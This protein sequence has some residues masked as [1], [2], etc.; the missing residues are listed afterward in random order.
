MYK[1]IDSEHQQICFLHFNQ[2]CGMQLDTQNEWVKH[3]DKLPWKAWEAPYAA[4]FTGIKGNVAKPSRMV[5]GSLIIQLRMGLTDRDLVNQI[6]ENP[7]YQYFIG[8]KEFQHNPPFVPTLL[9]EWRKRISVDFIIKANDILSAA[10]PQAPKDQR[11]FGLKVSGTLVATQICDA[12]VAPQNIRFPQD[13]SLLN[14]CREKL[15]AMID[16]LCEK[17]SLQ[18]PRIYRKVAHREYLDFAKSKKPSKD[19]IDRTI[20]A[21]LGY[22]RRDLKCLDE[23]LQGDHELDKRSTELLPTIR[24]V[25][26]QQKYMFDNHTHKVEDRIV[27]ITQPYVRPIVRGKAKSPTEFGAKLHLSIDERGFGR[28]EHLSFDAYN[29]GPMLQQAIEAYKYRTGV[30]P[31]RVLVDQL[32]RTKANIAFCNK[33]GIR[34]SGPK[35]GRPSKDKKTRNKEAKVAAKDSVDRIQI[36]RFF[37][38]AKRRYGLGLITKKREDTSLSTIA[39]SIFVTNIF[40]SFKFALEELKSETET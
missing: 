38:T 27:S 30:Y 24:K 31:E 10:M 20:K 1:S 22:V 9:V 14:E 8:L 12:T 17:Y 33:N 15:E 2:S 5:L 25:Y 16:Q 7:Y 28:I 11:S 36:E 3:A 18:K 4:M 35:L 32:Y 6:Q 39:M 29:E 37:S 13:T 21:Q 19:K 26:E 23:L 40:G 34:I